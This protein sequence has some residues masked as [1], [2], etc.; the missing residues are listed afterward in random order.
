MPPLPI[1]PPPPPTL[2]P[3]E[4]YL[5]VRE[6]G[7]EGTTPFLGIRRLRVNLRRQS[8]NTQ[9]YAQVLYRSNTRNVTD[10]TTWFQDVS[11]RQTHKNGIFTFGQFR[12]PFSR[13]RLTSDRE[14]L[15]LDRAVAVDAIMPG[16]GMNGSFARDRGVQ[17]EQA[18]PQNLN[19]TVGV[20]QGSGTFQQPGIGTGS[21]LVAVRALK[22]E[23]S[24]EYGIALTSRQS[25]HRDF[26]KALPGAA[27][28]LS[29]FSG[30]D[31]R[32]GLEWSQRTKTTRTNAEFLTAHF[33]GNAG[34]AR[35]TA[36]GGYIERAT[37]LQK[38]VPNAEWVAQVQY[39]NPDTSVFNTGDIWGYTLGVNL[40]P[41][42][43]KNRWQLNYA[44]RHE[45]R[46]ETPN[47]RVILQYQVYL[48][49]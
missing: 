21:P 40:T 27:S 16:A 20:F 10:N 25:S 39:F 46:K 49:R 2:P 22:R 6:T 44:V 36:S 34:S 13:Q 26:S 15:I 30:T 9:F 5:Q 19:L 47:N 24:Q 32:I 38:N 33:L 37:R 43:T 23:K 28:G 12:P 41:T 14:L 17:W 45:G 29:R 1:V 3:I 18:L 31:Q 4:S 42:N 7:G 35:R 8:K 48:T 11:M